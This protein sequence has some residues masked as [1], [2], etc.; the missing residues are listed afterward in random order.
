[1]YGKKIR[2]S[3]LIDPRFGRGVIIPYA[4]GL[5]QGPIPGLEDINEI[6]K[7]MEI[8]KYSRASGVIISYGYLKY[9]AEY[10]MGR[11]VPSLILLIDW[12]NMTKSYKG[13]VPYN[14]V[15]TTICTSIEDAIR[16]GA[17]GVMTY[18]TLGFDDPSM[19]AEEIKKNGLIVKECEKVGLPV[20]IEPVM[21]NFKNKEVFYDKDYLKVNDRIAAEIGADIVKSQFTGDAESFK[22]V[23]ENCAAP[24]MIAGGPKTGTIE[25][26]LHMIREAVNAGAAG[27][28]VGR[29]IFQ[30]EDVAGCL[31]EVCKIVYEGSPV[32]DNIQMKC[33]DGVCFKEPVD[34]DSLV[35]KIA[36]RVYEQY[37]KQSQS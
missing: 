30:S 27:T 8:F 16:C 36:D 5:L 7:Y 12:I 9:S 4:H 35:K 22:E 23:V 15:R 25:E 37:K 19:E 34:N 17:D 1:M 20:I 28:I 14:E 11:C 2:M 13:S 18:L 3:R 33:I 29:K 26:T 32:N 10:L 24:I 31:E 6:N 21:A